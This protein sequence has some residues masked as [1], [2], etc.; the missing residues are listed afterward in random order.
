MHEAADGLGQW[1]WASQPDFHDRT[2]TTPGRHF[3]RK[4]RLSFSKALY[5]TFCHGQTSAMA[6]RSQA[7]HSFREIANYGGRNH[8]GDYYSYGPSPDQRALQTLIDSLSYPGMKDRRD[9]LSEA[10][11]GTFEWAFL[12]GETEFVYDRWIRDDGEVHDY[13]NPVNI[14]FKAWLEGD[15]NGLFCFMGKPGSGKSTLM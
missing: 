14:D 11:R 8:F 2:L 12:E 5:P 10:S 7:G 6:D 9:A 1:P 13:S 3:A 15:G 4:S